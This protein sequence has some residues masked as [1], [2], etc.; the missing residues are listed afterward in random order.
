VTH[1]KRDEIKIL[2]VDPVHMLG[3]GQLSLLELLKTFDPRYLSGVACGD[4]HAEFVGALRSTR[5][6]VFP[7]YVPNLKRVLCIPA[8]ARGVA[9]LRKV[10][11]NFKPDIIHS[12][13]GR[14]HVLSAIAGR[15]CGVPVIWTMRA[16]DLP[17]PIYRLLVGAAEKVIFVSRHIASAYKRLPCDDK[18]CVIL[19]GILPPSINANLERAR[20]RKEYAIPHN[21]PVVASVGRLEPWKGQDHFIRAARIVKAML[22]DARFLIV[23]DG[24]S[25]PYRQRLQALASQ[26]SLR[27]SVTFTGFR[28]DAISC[29][30]ASDVVVHT[31]TLPEPFGRVIVEAM[32]VGVPVIA[33]PYGGPSEIIEHGS[34]GLLA[35]PE[36]VDELADAVIKILSDKEYAHRLAINGCAAFQERFHQRR[37]TEEVQRIYDEVAAIHSEYHGRYYGA[38]L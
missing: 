15:L 27:G 18:V 28:P 8:L 35:P 34:T 1:P 36:S 20:I 3:G 31:S 25:K 10:I 37:E 22:P 4:S 19:N 30:C 21:A 16:P 9:S 2:H 33:S 5:A 23:G 14:A 24:R 13:A 17:L 26:N 29:M 6:E 12:N 11:R 7:T 32:A 38:F